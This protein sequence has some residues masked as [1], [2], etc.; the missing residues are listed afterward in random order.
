[1]LTLHRK[2]LLVETAIG[3]GTQAHWHNYTPTGS[4]RFAGLVAG[5]APNNIIGIDANGKLV[6]NALPTGGV[7]NSCFTLNFV[8]KT[9]DAS[10]NLSCSQIYDDFKVCWYCNHFSFRC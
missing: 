6:E 7:R 8:P 1:M 9:I 3:L 5:G 4:V 2:N 10:G